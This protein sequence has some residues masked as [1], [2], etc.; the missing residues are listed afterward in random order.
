MGYKSWVEK[1]VLLW[2]HGVGYCLMPGIQPMQ[3]SPK[4]PDKN[5]MWDTPKVVIRFP[6]T[7]L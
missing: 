2:Q 3:W 7:N 4:C 6:T 5:S 1:I